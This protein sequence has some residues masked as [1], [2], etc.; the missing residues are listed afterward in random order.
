MKLDYGTQLSFDPI[1]L[2]IGTLKKPKLKDIS[3]ITFDKFEVYEIWLKMTPEKF[4]TK[5]KGKEGIKYWDSLKKEE[6][7]S[8]TLYDIVVNDEKLPSVYL[9]ILGFFFSEPVIYRSGYFVL[10]KCDIE[11]EELSKENIR[12]VINKE[13]FPQVLYV[14]QQICCVDDKEGMPG[15]GEFKNNLAKELFAKMLKNTKKEHAEK[16]S[17]KNYTIPNIISAVSSMHPSINF[18]NVWELTIFQLLD[19]FNRLRN[20]SM[21]TIDSIR[22]SVW[23]DEKKTYDAALWYKNEFDK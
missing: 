3:S 9:E 10:L 6:K 22:V 15:D 23:G 1:S 2:S 20:N 11:S 7:T 14:I 4:Y 16:K 19:C 8:I 5:I 18:V 12:G 21:F 17:D 13:L